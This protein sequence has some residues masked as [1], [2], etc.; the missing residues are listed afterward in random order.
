MYHYLP[1]I[2][3]D[4]HAAVQARRWQHGLQTFDDVDVTLKS[5]AVTGRP[6]CMTFVGLHPLVK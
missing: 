3:M 4:C 1:I 5:L 6:S 2:S